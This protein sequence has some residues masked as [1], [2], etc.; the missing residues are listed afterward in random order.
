[1]LR[2]E[3]ELYDGTGC[4]DVIAEQT[5][6]EMLLGMS[7]EDIVKVEVEENSLSLDEINEKFKDMLFLFHI[8]SS[9]TELRGRRYT[10][11]TIMTCL[12]ASEQPP[13]SETSKTQKR[14]LSDVLMSESQQSTYT[15]E[16]KLPPSHIV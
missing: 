15:V 5:E 9:S 4:L 12:R 6:A 7:G 14:P 16:E 2:F 8:R 1:M 3:A 13:T 10:R 11:N